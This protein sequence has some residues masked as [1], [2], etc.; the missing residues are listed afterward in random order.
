MSS[1][2]QPTGYPTWSTTMTST[3]HANGDAHHCAGRC[4]SRKMPKFHFMRQST[5]L[6]I[7]MNGDGSQ[8]RQRDTQSFAAK[9]VVSYFMHNVE[10][11]H[12]KRVVFDNYQ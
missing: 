7:D 12:V 6:K 2:C 8:R 10:I 11:Q 5:W 9:Q 3:L 1:E 4:K